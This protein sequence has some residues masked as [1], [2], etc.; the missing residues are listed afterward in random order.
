MA[1]FYSTPSRLEVLARSME[2]PVDELRWWIQL[3]VSDRK[4]AELMARAQ[5]PVADLREGFTD[6][7]R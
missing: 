7:R 1:L 2:V 4:Q 6:A 5:E 3:L